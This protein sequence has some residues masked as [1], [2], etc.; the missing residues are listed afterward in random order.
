MNGMKR[1]G[2][3]SLFVVLVAVGSP[4]AFAQGSAVEFVARATPSSG[5]EEPIRGFPFFLL[6]RSFQEIT[7]EADAHFPKPDMDAFIEKLKVSKELKDWMKKNHTVTLQGEEFIH[8]LKPDDVMKIQEFYNAYMSRNAGDEAYNFPKPKYTM[9]DREKHPDKY[10]KLKADYDSAVKKYMTDHPETI[11]GIDLDL[12]DTDPSKKWTDEEGKR[13]PAIRQQ[14]LGLAQG[15]YLVAR[16][17][18]DLEGHG[19]LRGLQPGKYWLTNLEVP[20]SVGDARLHWDLPV[21]VPAGGIATVALTN[22][23]AIQPAHATP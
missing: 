7:S 19:S 22:G 1:L 3:V 16:T 17:Q 21:T 10:A 11:D 6:S 20:A 12:V 8:L 15:K 5:I 23:N 18:T 13:R 2:A 14:A 9:Q 4:R